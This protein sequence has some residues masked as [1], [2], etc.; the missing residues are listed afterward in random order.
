MAQHGAYD[1][2]R[3][4]FVASTAP[5]YTREPLEDEGVHLG[6]VTIG[7]DATQIGTGE[8]GRVRGKL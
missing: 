8:G 4:P 2:F 1:P 7:K 6:G 5:A 3:A